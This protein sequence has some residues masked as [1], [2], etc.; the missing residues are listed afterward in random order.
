MQ[1]YALCQFGVLE[2]FNFESIKLIVIWDQRP[3]IEMI[4]GGN[5]DRWDRTLEC[6]LLCVDIWR[7][8]FLQSI[9][10]WSIFM[11]WALLSSPFSV[12]DRYLSQSD[13]VEVC[14]TS[15][16]VGH[17]KLFG[18]FFF[19]KINISAGKRFSRIPFVLES[20]VQCGYFMDF[21]WEIW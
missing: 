8:I 16:V 20:T 15:L 1:S 10:R 18:I 17:K 14:K 13:H 21:F 3:V 9:N 5:S 7:F 19:R 11:N 6:S 2:R 12:L 4:L